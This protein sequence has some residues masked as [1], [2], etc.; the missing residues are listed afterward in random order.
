MRPVGAYIFAAGLPLLLS[1]A[2]R[3]VPLDL[4]KAL[5]LEVLAAPV[6]V[7]GKGIEVTFVTHNS[8]NGHLSLCSPGGLTTY[9]QSQSPAYIWAIGVHGFT[10]DTYCS[11]PFDLPPGGTKVFVERGG[12][13]NDLPAGSPSLIGK[14]SLYCDPTKHDAC[15]N[16]EL[17]T[18]E[19]VTIRVA[20]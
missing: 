15:T 2:H 6:I 1:C 16:A 19:S 8:T 18:V 9:V 5:T 7:P 10:T 17:Q 4:A 3:S 20:P 12:I 13:G 11:G 14:I